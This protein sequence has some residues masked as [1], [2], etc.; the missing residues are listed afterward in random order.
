[1]LIPQGK[2]VGIANVVGAVITPARHTIV[3]VRRHLRVGGIMTL[4]LLLAFGPVV[5]FAIAI[6]VIGG[7]LAS[8]TKRSS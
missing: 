4:R 6:R 5:L 2:G 1:V 8:R 3:V 7:R